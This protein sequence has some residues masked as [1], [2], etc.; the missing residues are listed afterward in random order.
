MLSRLI[1][2]SSLL[3]IMKPKHFFL[4]TS[5]HFYLS[6]NPMP[7]L[8]S[9]PVAPSP[10]RT[11]IKRETCIPPKEESLISSCGDLRAVD[12]LE[13]FSFPEAEVVFCPCLVVI[14]CHKEGD[15]CRGGKKHSVST[16]QLSE[17][18]S[19]LE[20]CLT[21]DAVN[22]DQSLFWMWG[23]HV[24]FNDN[25]HHILQ[26]MIDD[27]TECKQA[28]EDA[29]DML[30]NNKTLVLSI[31]TGTYPVWILL[32]SLSQCWSLKHLENYWTD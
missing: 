28:T 11:A 7:C 15:S 14:K 12:N 20:S 25:I 10:P 27:Q 16:L 1:L 19:S 31:Q 4:S 13:P 26:M 32:L 2:G 8:L 9:L 6:W 30:S 29:K 23:S 17:R 22:R 24:G 5:C 3:Q 21:D 18:K